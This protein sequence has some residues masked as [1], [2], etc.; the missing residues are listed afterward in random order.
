MSTK[1]N[2]VEPDIIATIFQEVEI[3]IAK[4]SHFGHNLQVSKRQ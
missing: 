1:K 3:L 2:I 4:L